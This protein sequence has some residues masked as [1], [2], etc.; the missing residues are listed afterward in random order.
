M[1]QKGH[2]VAA[3]TPLHIKAKYGKGYRLTLTSSE[4]PQ[5]TKPPVISATLESSAAGQIVWRI[6][7]SKD[8]VSAVRWADEKERE[9]QLREGRQEG[10]SDDEF[11]RIEAWEISM[12]TLEDVLLERNLF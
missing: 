4:E 12:P 9:T 3:G 2:I 10:R 6:E 7:D 5:A 11:V 1:M 8:L